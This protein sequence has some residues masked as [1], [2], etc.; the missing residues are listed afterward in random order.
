MLKLGNTKAAAKVVFFDQFI[1]MPFIYLPMFYV[2]R[3]FG[4]GNPSTSF[5]EKVDQAK[6]EYKKSIR[7]DLF[8][9]MM[10]YIP[11]QT[12]NFTLVSPHFRIPFLNLIGVGYIFCLSYTRGSYSVEVH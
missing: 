4:M 1:H 6:V 9:E 10:I 12:L 5:E 3:E 2:L 11:A 8:L 7:D